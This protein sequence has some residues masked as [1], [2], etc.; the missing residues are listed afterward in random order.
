[1]VVATGAG[2]GSGC[3]SASRWV[4][5]DDLSYSMVVAGEARRKEGRRGGRK[6]GRRGG[7][8]EGTPHTQP[9]AE[10]V[11]FPQRERQKTDQLYFLSTRAWQVQVRSSFTRSGEVR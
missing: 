3:W 8:K 5:A 7:R 9:L 2:R 6:E 4:E 1:M 10:I 11:T